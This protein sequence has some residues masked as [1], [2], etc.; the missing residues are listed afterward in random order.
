[1]SSVLTP[2]LAL[3]NKITVPASSQIAVWSEGAFRVYQVGRYTNFPTPDPG[4]LL[5]DAAANSAEYVS[6]F[7]AAADVQIDPS[8]GQNVYYE[9]GTAPR[10]KRA[11]QVNPRQTTPVALNASGAI[12]SAAIL[13]RLVTSTTAA[14]VAA[15]LPTGT[16]LAAAS[17]W[18]LLEAVDWVI[19]NTGPNTFTVTAA[20]DHTVVGG[21][22]AAFVVPT[23]TSCFARTVQVT[24][25]VFVTYAA[26][27]PIS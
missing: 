12:T 3:T 2:L 7:S 8:R 23:L 18:A 14:A 24:A 19:V 17:N 1:M 21:A 6:A 4:T 27:R 5:T 22:G 13:G 25:G 26:A 16:V 10:V 11:W 20:T 9:V 15:D